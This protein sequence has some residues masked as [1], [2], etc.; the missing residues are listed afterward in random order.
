MAGEHR[1]QARD[2]HLHR[3]LHQVIEPGMFER[4]EQ[5]M[6]VGRPRLLA[7]ALADDRRQRPLAGAGEPG[8][9]FAVAAVEQE[10]LIP[11]LE[12]QHV[13]QIIRLG[14]VE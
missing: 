8:L 13:K 2:A 1:L 7:P 12:P 10:Q 14:A 3:L 6:Q 4:G 5:K 11:V 9:P